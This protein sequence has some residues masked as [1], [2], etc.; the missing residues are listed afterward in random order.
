MMMRA[1]KLTGLSSLLRKTKFGFCLNGM[2]LLDPRKHNTMN[3][4]HHNMYL[5]IYEYGQYPEIF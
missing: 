5:D 4:N 3:H 2:A 1:V